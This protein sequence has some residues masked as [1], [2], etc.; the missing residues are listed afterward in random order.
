MQTVQKMVGLPGLEPGT[1]PLSGVHSNQLS[2]R[3][4]WGAFCSIFR[5]NLYSI[6]HVHK[7]VTHSIKNPPQS[8]QKSL[9]KHLIKNALEDFPF[10]I[11]KY[12]RTLDH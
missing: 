8:E 11:I 4:F 7:Y 10:N 12:H 5:W 3:P 2:Y 6:R 1:S 9:P